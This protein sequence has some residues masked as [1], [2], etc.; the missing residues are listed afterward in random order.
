ML[1]ESFNCGPRRN[2]AVSA[3]GHHQLGAGAEVDLHRGAP[4]ISQLLAAA[5]RTLRAARHVVL[6]HRRTQKVEADD[7]I[8]QFSAKAGGDGFGD[9]DRGKLD[10]ALPEGIASKRRDG[11]GACSSALEKPFDLA[12]ADHAIEQT[13][14]AGRL[15]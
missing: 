13:G 10:A 4:W 8:A 1:A 11:N 7:V 2:A 9:F 14:P 5:G 15:A 6:R 12:V 3:A